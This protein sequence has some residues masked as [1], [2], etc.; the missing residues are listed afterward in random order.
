[1]RAGKPA[2]DNIVKKWRNGDFDYLGDRHNHGIHL[3]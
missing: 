3:F 2:V 1:M